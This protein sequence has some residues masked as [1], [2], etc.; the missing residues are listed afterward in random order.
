[1]ATLEIITAPAGAGKSA[2]CR[3]R[4]R[5]CPHSWLILP[6]EEQ[7]ARWRHTLPDR[8]ADITTA[9]ELAHHLAAPGQRRRRGAD[10]AF[11]LLVLRHLIQRETGPES[12]FARVADTA[13]F[14]RCLSDLFSQLRQSETDAEGLSAAVRAAAPELA[15][16]TFAA[17]GEEIA[18]L[19]R[20]YDAYLHQHR[21]LDAEGLL[22]RAFQRVREA[23]DR[24]P[25]PA[26]IIVHGFR[27]FTPQQ[28]S[29][30]QALAGRVGRLT[31]TLS[32]DASRPVLFAHTGEALRR[33]RDRFPDAAL[34]ELPAAPGDGASAGLRLMESRLFRGGPTVPPPDEAVTLFEAPDPRIQLEM[35]AR[36][37]RRLLRP[38]GLPPR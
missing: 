2:L 28:L 21:L 26:K 16:G 17:K 29:L 35:V 27:E 37:I 6:S 25:W 36:E 9:Q 13:G 31:V 30:F 22:A 15:D 14:A 8:A 3:Q 4:L 11:R 38:G 34:H 33:L 5:E 23:P 12:L 19:L 1:M 7:R 32:H 24:F 10:T 20:A 18:R